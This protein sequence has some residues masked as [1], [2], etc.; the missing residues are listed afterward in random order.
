MKKTIIGVVIVVLLA[1]GA[2]FLF[3]RPSDTDVVPNGPDTTQGPDGAQPTSTAP[4][5]PEDGPESVI[6][7]SV[8]GRDITAY[9]FGSG[10]T[11][12]LFVGGIHGGYE[13]N[14]SLVAF[15]LIDHLK[16]NPNVIPEG[17]R[18]TVIPILNPDGLNKVVGVAGRFA[19]ADVTAS[20]A[21]QVTGRFNANNVDLNR[22][23]D[24]DWQA[25]AK[26]Q[27]KTVSGGTAAFSE[28]E[29]AAM[30]AYIEARRPD[31]VVVWYSAAGGVFSS[32]CHDGVL[33]ETNALTN[34]YAKAS[35]Y[36]GYESYDF[37]ETTGDM[38]NWLAKIKV[39]AISVLLTNHT[40]TEWSKNRAGAEAI[41][42]Y[43]AE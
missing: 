19:A 3:G 35:G 20:A 11:D 36:K 12:V 14:T 15:E 43:Y 32:S 9:H 22:N 16:N 39:P 28:P 37:Y 8:E 42:K 41:L 27:D 30:K 21:V 26:W 24:C 31:A 10:S 25:S 40:G 33:A 29:S 1:V 34:A 7:K 38:A 6:G 13:W 5:A 23:F 4:T 2:Y 17:V 18:V